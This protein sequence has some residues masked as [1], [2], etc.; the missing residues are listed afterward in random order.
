MTTDIE[1]QQPVG[2]HAQDT[3]AKSF[4]GRADGFEN[5]TAESPSS[6]TPKPVK[7]VPQL[8]SSASNDQDAVVDCD[9]GVHVIVAVSYG[10]HSAVLI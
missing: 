1:T 2:V 7:A 3:P 4:F 6:D 9:C 5:Q 8:S 10:T